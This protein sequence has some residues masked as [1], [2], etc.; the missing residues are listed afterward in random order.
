MKTSFD[1]FNE[2]QMTASAETFA[3]EMLSS[4]LISDR[5]LLHKW[6]IRKALERHDYADGIFA[7][8][9]VHRADS[10]N[11]F[12]DFLKGSGKKIYGFD[13]FEGIEEDW[14]ADRL[15][16]RYSL[17][18]VLPKVRDNAVLIKGWV[19]DTLED[20]LKEHP[21]DYFSFIHL[22]L[23]TYSPT[24]FVLDKLKEKIRPGT[25]VLFDELHGYPQWKAHEY[26]ALQESLDQ[27][28]YKY[29]AFGLQQ[30]VIEIIN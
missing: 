13:A 19:Q 16:G 26:K 20:F 22:D 4:T 12:A 1:Y 3:P 21:S 18:G 24:R 6:V 9:G 14:D 8:F 29:I 15:K 23:D 2:M 7:E 30:A 5:T 25:I 28:R 10:L 11:L 27:S 17:G